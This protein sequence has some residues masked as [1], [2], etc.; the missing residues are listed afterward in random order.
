MSINVPI[1]ANV[2]SKDT[3]Y[4]LIP[5]DST[6][7]SSIGISGPIIFQQVGEQRKY[8]IT[9]KATNVAVKRMLDG[10]IITHHTPGTNL[11]M[12]EFTFSPASPT[13]Q[14]L[15]NVAKYQD[16]VGPVAFSLNVTNVVGATTTQYDLVFL[17]NPFSGYEENERQED[18]VFTFTTVPPSLVNI[19]SL[20]NAI[21]NVL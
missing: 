19:G 20:A 21:G 1:V 8:N 12:V 10:N 9:Q 17:T 14:T 16:Q 11:T 6:L 3:I 18:V 2:S 15:A 13:V 5:S 7:L 4:T